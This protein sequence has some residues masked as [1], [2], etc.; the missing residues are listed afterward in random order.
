MFSLTLR[1]RTMYFLTLSLG[2]QDVH[3][4]SVAL[5]WTNKGICRVLICSAQVRFII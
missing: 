2:H 5:Q 4:C 3:E 1:Y